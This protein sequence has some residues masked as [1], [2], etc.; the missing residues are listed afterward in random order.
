VS[1]NKLYGLTKKIASGAYLKP[2]HD[3]VRAKIMVI[4]F[5]SNIGYGALS[6]ALN[7][8]M[9]GVDMTSSMI[10]QMLRMALMGYACVPLTFW[11]LTKF[12]SPL[13][14]LVL[15]ILGLGFFLIDPSSGL[16]NAIGI[17][18]AFSPFLA[19]QQYRFAK[20]QS[21]EN[22]G[23]EVAL[24]SF[25]ISMSYSFGLFLGGLLL[26]HDMLA[27]ATLGGS[28]CTIIGAYFLYYPISSHGNAHKVWSLVGRNKPSSR[29]TF[30]FG[31]FNPMVDGC[32]PVWMRVMGISPMGAGINMS[33][34]PLIGL[35]L[36][37][38]VGWLIQKK[39]LRAAQLGGIGM[40]L[41]WSLMAG[42]HVFPWMLAIGFAI[43]STGTNL[44][45]PMEVGR[46]MKRRSAAAVICRE[47]II[48]TGRIPAYGMGIVT[49]FLA[50][51]AF[52]LLGLIISGAFMFGTRPKR[53]G[54]GGKRK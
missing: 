45:N 51:L 34:R 38:L 36:T 37:P 18:I 24:N 40:I 50:P 1:V 6:F 41:G 15:Q 22:R 30:F 9:A 3:V 10:Y 8:S 27:E 14:L 39:G 26:Y 28:L 32:M 46:W 5:L 54:L 13:L 49:S 2:W 4:N 35:F 16:F 29:I 43:L 44:L 52:P 23:N 12:K 11:F 53:R 48:A 33:L 31:L 19:L 17:S 21:E 25:L 42:S 20:N 7:Y 47:S